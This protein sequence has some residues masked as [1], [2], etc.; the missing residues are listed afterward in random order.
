[1]F[2]TIYSKL[3]YISEFHNLRYILLLILVSKQIKYVNFLC[4]VDII[5]RSFY[6]TSSLIIFCIF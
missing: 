4:I 1:M 3:T 5:C 2:K 6:N